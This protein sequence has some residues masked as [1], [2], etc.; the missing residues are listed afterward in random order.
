MNREKLKKLHNFVKS[1]VKDDWFNLEK[2]ASDIAAFKNKE[3]GT[4]ACL[5]GWAVVVF[6]DELRWADDV[7]SS[8]GHK[9]IRKD[10]HAYQ[11]EYVTA[12]QTFDLTEN[13]AHFLFCPF[14]YPEGSHTT[15]LDVLK[16]LEWFFTH[17]PDDF[18]INMQAAGL[19]LIPVGME[20]H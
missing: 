9:I 5:F 11:D 20:T 4:T 7:E 10:A 18:G 12:Q 3:C 19:D 2:W 13:Q 15:R 6:P 8:L 14:R 17:A 16:R 1:E